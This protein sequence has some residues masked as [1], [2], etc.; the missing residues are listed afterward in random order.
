MPTYGIALHP[1][2]PDLLGPLIAPYTHQGA[3]ALYILAE[4]ASN[5]GNFIVAEV[6]PAQV[7]GRIRSPMTLWLRSEH[8]LFVA[9]SE[10]SPPLGFHTGSS[11]SVAPGSQEESTP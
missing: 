8:V 6:Q 10:D 7:A 11:P 5:Q 2:A 1:K 9:V 4:S 3:T